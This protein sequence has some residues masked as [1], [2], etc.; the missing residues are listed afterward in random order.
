MKYIRLFI[1]LSIIASPCLQAIN[2]HTLFRPGASE[3]PIQDFD[4]WPVPGASRE[5]PGLLATIT[6][7]LDKGLK[8]D[9]TVNASA[10][11]TDALDDVAEGTS[12]LSN[13]IPI[14]TFKA[15]QKLLIHCK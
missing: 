7:A 15:S 4:M 12:R 9:A 14:E 11:V 8:V 13:G 5:S 2:L 10:S 1:I 3:Q 6:A